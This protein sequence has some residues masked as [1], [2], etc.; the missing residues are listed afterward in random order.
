MTLQTTQEVLSIEIERYSRDGHIVHTAPF[1]RGK[2][3]TGQYY[4]V[5][6]KMFLVDVA[7]ADNEIGRRIVE[8]TLDVCGVGHV[9]AHAQG[10]TVIY[11]WWVRE[12][13][14]VKIDVL[15]ILQEELGSEIRL[16]REY[17]RTEYDPFRL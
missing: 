12:W 5:G 15:R 4:H 14:E 7:D 10:L 1:V 3:L 17:N 8:R 11:R 6:E 16:E 13:D 2:R 9:V